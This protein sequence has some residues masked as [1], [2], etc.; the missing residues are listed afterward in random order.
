MLLKKFKMGRQEPGQVNPTNWAKY[1]WTRSSPRAS[2]LRNRESVLTTGESPIAPYQP[3]SAQNKNTTYQSFA[4]EQIKQDRLQDEPPADKSGEFF[5]IAA[6][7]DEVA[8]SR[9]VQKSVER[10]LGKQVD[11]FIG[12]LRQERAQDEELVQDKMRTLS[13]KG[14]LGTGLAFLP[15]RAS[16]I[17]SYNRASALSANMSTNQVS[18][19]SR[20]TPTRK[21][22]GLRQ[23][24][25]PVRN[26]DVSN[27]SGSF[28]DN[29]VMQASELNPQLKVNLEM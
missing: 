11:G 20:Q 4:A 16:H 9:S 23:S 18:G 29:S 27:K 21:S 2:R 26:F 12:E 17:P 13:S 25:S 10:H 6:Y 8:I 19:A 5:R 14:T 28:I 7:K 1:D 15:N 24:H 3:P 22:G